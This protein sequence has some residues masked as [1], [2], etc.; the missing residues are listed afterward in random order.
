[1]DI[2]GRLEAGAKGIWRLSDL[3]INSLML[4]AVGEIK[5]LQSQLALDGRLRNSL[6]TE[7]AELRAELERQR[8][9]IESWKALVRDY[10]GK[11]ERLQRVI[12]TTMTPREVKQ[13]L[14][15]CNILA[16]AYADQNV[17]IKELRAEIKQL[18]E[19]CNDKDE[20]ILDQHDEIERLRADERRLSEAG[21]CRDE[22]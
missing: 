5:Q 18:Q 17:T 12:K 8:G 22:T 21:T 16:D 10:E 19:A 6:N 7:L 4:E 11:I 20:L 3:Q 9:E 13:Q 2:V 1:M 14:A 15:E